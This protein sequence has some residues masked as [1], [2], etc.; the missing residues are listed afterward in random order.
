MLI[1]IQHEICVVNLSM[2]E[3]GN[4]KRRKIISATKRKAP[5]DRISIPKG[6]TSG[7]YVQFINDV[8]DIMNEFPEMGDTKPKECKDSGFNCKID[9]RVT[10]NATKH[11]DLS[12][13]EYAKKPGTSKYY[14]DKLKLVLSGFIHLR[15]YISSNDTTAELKSVPLILVEGLEGESFVLFIVDNDW[16][17]I[18]KIENIDVPNNVD[19]IKNGDIKSYID[20]LNLFKVCGLLPECK[21]QNI[22]NKKMKNITQAKKQPD[23]SLKK[24]IWKSEFVD[25]SSDDE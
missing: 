2:R 21:K 10:T 23:I 12:A 5:E 16:L 15:K 13:A 8:M 25:E 9:L 3:S 14:T 11:I 4:I 24:P 7:H 18:Q 22:R 19:S 20:G 17:A 6:T 1:T